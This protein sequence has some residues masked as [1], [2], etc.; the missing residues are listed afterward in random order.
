[1]KIL[2]A[3]GF[4]AGKTTFVRSISEIKPLS[5]EETLT[6]ASVPVDSLD[7]IPDKKT[8]TVAMDFGRRTIAADLRL[9]LF[10]TPGQDRFWFMWDELSRGAFGAI[11]LVDTR[12]ITDSF[13]AIEFFESRGIRFLVAVNQFQGAPVYPESDVRTALALR[14]HVPLI[15]C[16]ARTFQSTKAVLILLVEHIVNTRR[17]EDAARVAAPLPSGSGARYD[18]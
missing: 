16:D 3:G 7:G 8:T 12:R 9:L 1:M 10:G 14:E 17:E 6:V 13:G 2:I 18:V 15:R 4:G 11:V 5:T